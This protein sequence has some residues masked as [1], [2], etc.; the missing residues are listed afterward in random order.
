M[1]AF[2]GATNCTCWVYWR[3]GIVVLEIGLTDT[4]FVILFWPHRQGLSADQLF[5]GPHQIDG[6]RKRHPVWYCI[7]V[8]KLRGAYGENVIPWNSIVGLC[9]LSGRLPSNWSPDFVLSDFRTSSQPIQHG[10]I[11]FIEHPWEVP[12]TLLFRPVFHCLRANMWRVEAS[13]GSN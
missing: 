2:R 12:L 4:L 5:S 13:L 10:L 7:R 6:R 1:P 11:L 9:R 8:C 3:P